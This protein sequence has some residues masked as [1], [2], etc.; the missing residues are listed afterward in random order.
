MHAAFFFHPRYEAHGVFATAEV[1]AFLQ[2]VN[3]LRGEACRGAPGHTPGRPPEPRTGWPWP[4]RESS[5]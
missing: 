3:K 5:R 1:K 2:L 4:W